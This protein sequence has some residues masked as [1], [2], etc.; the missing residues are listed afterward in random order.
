M[1]I[2]LVHAALY[3]LH[4]GYYEESDVDC[5][6]PIAVATTAAITNTIA[7]TTSATPLRHCNPGRVCRRT[8]NP[9]DAQVR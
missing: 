4:A 2:G 6:A 3:N 5:S 7:A 8:Q 1:V 9:S